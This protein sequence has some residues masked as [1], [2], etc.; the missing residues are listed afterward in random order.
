MSTDTEQFTSPRRQDVQFADKEQPLRDDVRTLGS[1][2]GDLIRE[3]GG[4]ELF[5]P[6][7]PAKGV[8]RL[9]QLEPGRRFRPW[10]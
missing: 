6:F 5:E 4:E 1:M 10:R 9:Q 3:Q 8:H 2:V 7:G